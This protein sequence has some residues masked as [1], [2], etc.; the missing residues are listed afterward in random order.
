MAAGREAVL[1]SPGWDLVTDIVFR[2]CS[3]DL[4]VRLGELPRPAM[5]A[6]LQVPGRMLDDAEFQVL[7]ECGF[8]SGLGGL[9]L[10]FNRIGDEGALRPGRVAGGRDAALAEPRQRQPRLRR[11]HGPVPFALPGLG[12]APV[13]QGQLPDGP[14]RV[15]PP[16]AVRPSHHA[17][18]N[19]G[20]ADLFRPGRSSGRL[21]I[22]HQASARREPAVKRTAGSRRAARRHSSPPRNILLPPWTPPL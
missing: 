11:G 13:G 21:S 10:A 2:T 22:N 5:L 18:L 3:L 20:P 16:R 19:K 4:L 8:W 15:R 1:A 17:R 6:D 7:L 14:R 12:A 9:S